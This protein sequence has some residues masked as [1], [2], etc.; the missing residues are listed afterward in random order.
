VQI[1]GGYGYMHDYFVEKIMRDI[2]VLQLL[3]GSSP[4]L[5]IRIIREPLLRIIACG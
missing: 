5:N 1:Q 3:G 2:K 4:V